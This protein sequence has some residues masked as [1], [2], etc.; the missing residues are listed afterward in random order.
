MDLAGRHHQADQRREDDQRH[1]PRLQ[2]REIVAR[3]AIGMA[4]AGGQF[5]SCSL[6][7]AMRQFAFPCLRSGDRRFVRDLQTQ[8]AGWPAVCFSCRLR[9][10]YLMRGSCSHWW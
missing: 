3:I 8:T 5:S 1:H 10:A 6:V 2:Q 7:I 4:T 9:R